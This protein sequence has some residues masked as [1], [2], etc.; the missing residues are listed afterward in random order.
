M[1]EL[2]DRQV[3]IPVALA[4]GVGVVLVTGMSFLPPWVGFA[5][6]VIALPL[7]VK[8]WKVTRRAEAEWVDCPY[9][10]LRIRCTELGWAVDHV[11]SHVR[12]NHSDRAS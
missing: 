2:F 11:A 4:L 1:M 12:S 6:V 7:Y 3:E 9:C 8:A 10:E 5:G